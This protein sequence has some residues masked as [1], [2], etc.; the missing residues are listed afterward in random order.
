M[1]LVHWKN[2]INQ[3]TEYRQKSGT[4][5]CVTVWGGEPLVSPYFDEI[6]TLL[7][8]KDFETEVITNGVLIDR[9][10][11]VIGSKADRLYVSIDGPK[12]IHDSIR[13]NGVYDKVRDN[14][15]RLKHKHVIVMSVITSQL[16]ECLPQFISELNGLGI[17]ELYL[18]DMI[19]L[20]TE[21]VIQYKEW[22]KKAFDITAVNI[23][24]WESNEKID[25]TEQIDAVLEDIDKSNL[26][27]E[28]AQK[29]HRQSP[30]LHCISPYNHM[31]IA[32]NGNV[33]Y[34]TDFYDFVAG[35]VHTDTLE[36]IFLNKKSEAYR[37]EI[38]K[39]NC[40]SCKHCSWRLTEFE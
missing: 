25:F 34:C 9:H 6:L 1:T 40:P 16:V 18:Q 15:I 14:L 38:T 11:E 35:N 36:S 29:S 27:F 28:I 17:K 21:E 4:N 32:W 39:G 19:G 8:D 31:H 20:T 3:L 37:E 7:K 23:D 10:T 30:H 33:L 13:G 5:I 2:I 22:M 26:S 24:S 12:E